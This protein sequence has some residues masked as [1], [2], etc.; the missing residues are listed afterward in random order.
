MAF[1]NLGLGKDFSE[2]TNRKKKD[3]FDFKTLKTSVHQNIPLKKMH[4]KT[5]D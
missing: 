5:P 2:N 4:R 1:C 3:K